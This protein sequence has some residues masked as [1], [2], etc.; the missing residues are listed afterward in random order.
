MCHVRSVRLPFR[1]VFACLACLECNIF[2]VK[3]FHLDVIGTVVEW[4]MGLEGSWEGGAAS[5]LNC[6]KL[7]SFIEIA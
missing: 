6:W 3:T 7:N 4:I 5:Q 1:I 2:P